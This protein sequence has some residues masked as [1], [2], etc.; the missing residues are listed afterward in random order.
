MNLSAPFVA[1]PIATALL[2]LAIVVLGAISYRLLPVAAL[3]D[4]DTPTT[5]LRVDRTPLPAR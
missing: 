5:A 4:I 3:P 2:M 1:R